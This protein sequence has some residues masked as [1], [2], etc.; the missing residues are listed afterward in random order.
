[1]NILE[2]KE[3][4]KIE[5]GLMFESKQTKDSYTSALNKFLSEND[6]VYNLSVN[7][8]KKYFSN[9]KIRYSNSY[10]NVICSAVKIF[11]EKVLGQKQKMNWFKPIKSERKQVQ[12]ITFDDFK[13]IMSNIKSLKQKTIT[14]ILYSTGIR[15][16]EL[17]NLKLEDVD[18]I[19]QRFLIHSLKHGKDRFVP[20]HDLVVKYIQKYIKQYCPNEYL[21]YGQNSN[22]YSDSSIRQFLKRAGEGLNK[23]IYPHKFRH[24]FGTEMADHINIFDLKELFGHKDLKSTMHYYHIPIEKLHKLYNPLNIKN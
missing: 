10:Y 9:F 15:I 13:H 22:Q 4:Y 7:D 2:L 8:L 23:N 16:S 20:M 17:L 21:F 11:Y 3:K 12:V 24:S 14:I 5:I 19:N 6:Y 18:I 1:M